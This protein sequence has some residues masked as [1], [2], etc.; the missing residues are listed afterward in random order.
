MDTFLASHR[1]H[2]PAWESITS[3]DF[4][5]SLAT[6][7]SSKKP[8]ARRIN[9]DLGPTWKKARSGSVLL[10]HVVLWPFEITSPSLVF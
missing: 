2:H 3:S 7:E 10:H 9:E 1:G 4:D 5:W 8:V 6:R